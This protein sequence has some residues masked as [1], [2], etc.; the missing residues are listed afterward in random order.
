[1][2]S[3]DIRKARLYFLDGHVM[4]Y[5]DPKLAYAVWLALPKGT[6]VAFRG[7]NDLLAVYSWDYGDRR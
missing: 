1:V 3:I 2:D 7:S 4:Q 5:D 6:R